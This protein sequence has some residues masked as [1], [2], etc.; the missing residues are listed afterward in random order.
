MF[1]QQNNNL[2]LTGSDKRY[3]SIASNTPCPEPAE[4]LYPNCDAYVWL[5]SCEREIIEP[6]NGKVTGVIPKWIKG[7]L[8][9]NGPGNLKVGN[10]KFKH[11]FDSSALLH[12]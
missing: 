10:M 12:R 2:K 4:K 9:R 8:L 7:S 1:F 5:R 11:L 6:I 3:T